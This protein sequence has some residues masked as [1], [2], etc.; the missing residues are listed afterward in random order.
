MPRRAGGCVGDPVAESQPDVAI[1]YPLVIAQSEPHA[2][3]DVPDSD[4]V[5]DV[6]DTD[7]VTDV[8]D[9]DAI[10]D[11]PHTEAVT[12]AILFASPG[13]CSLSDPYSQ[14]QATA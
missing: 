9:S 5:T 11:V 4:A 6:P 2:V 13:S 1:A 12:D 10:T 14:R 8:P 7:A 3:T